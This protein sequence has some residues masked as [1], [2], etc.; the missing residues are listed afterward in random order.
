[1][2][3]HENYLPPKSHP[4]NGVCL[5]Q[6]RSFAHLI[7]IIAVFSLRSTDIFSVLWFFKSFEYCTKNVFVKTMFDW[8]NHT[9]CLDFGP[10]KPQL[11][12][13]AY[14]RPRISLQKFNLKIICWFFFSI[15]HHINYLKLSL[16]WCLWFIR[17]VIGMCASLR[18]IILYTL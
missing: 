3:K 1:M 6:M 2:N 10:I 4:P 7:L 9:S 12:R 5:C 16:K 13:M 11:N 18:Y 8:I 15:L 17:L 14:Y